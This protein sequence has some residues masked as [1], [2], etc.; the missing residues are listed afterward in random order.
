MAEVAIKNDNIVPYGGI[1]FAMNESRRTGL[2]KL[3]EDEPNVLEG[4]SFVTSDGGRGVLCSHINQHMVKS[5]SEQ[6]KSHSWR[7]GPQRSDT[8]SRVAELNLH[9]KF[10]PLA[11][12]AD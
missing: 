5:L 11:D 8:F 2:D 12:S 7:F 4:L 3:A 10:L 6:E 9:A 1:F